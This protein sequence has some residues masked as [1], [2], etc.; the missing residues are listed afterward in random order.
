[1]WLVHYEFE[2]EEGFF[3]YK[4]GE[5]CWGFIHNLSFLMCSFRNGEPTRDELKDDDTL[6]IPFDFIEGGHLC[7]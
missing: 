4:D 7:G 3:I 1:M 2:S 6:C 5:N